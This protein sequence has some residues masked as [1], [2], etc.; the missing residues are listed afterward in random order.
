MHC[1]PFIFL[2]LGLIICDVR[3]FQILTFVEI[4][5]NE[6]CSPLKINQLPNRVV[7]LQEGRNPFFR[8]VE[9]ER[10]FVDTPIICDAHNPKFENGSVHE[11]REIKIV[12]YLAG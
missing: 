10:S 8:N 4:K 6:E 12:K 3:D 2:S 1:F 5:V 11:N 9:L 7:K